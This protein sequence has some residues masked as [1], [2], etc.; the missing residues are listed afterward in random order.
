MFTDSSRKCSFGFTSLAFHAIRI[1]P[2]Q[3]FK[4]S[5]FSEHIKFELRLF[6]VPVVLRIPE[7]GAVSDTVLRALC[8]LR[9]DYHIVILSAD[10]GIDY[11]Q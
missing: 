4:I 11:I 5:A 6:I 2:K 1:E 8:K 10:Y 3:A 7:P 9:K